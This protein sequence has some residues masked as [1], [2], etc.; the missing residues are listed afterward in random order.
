MAVL[1][2]P[3]SAQ[4]YVGPGIGIGSIAAALALVLGVL[5][6]MAGFLWYPLKRMMRGAKVPTA[7][8]PDPTKRG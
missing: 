1:S 8:H 2:F 5:L 7:D 6:L 4:A 3:L